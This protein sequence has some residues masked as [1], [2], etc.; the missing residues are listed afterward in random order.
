MP[1]K[2]IHGSAKSCPFVLLLKIEIRRAAEKSV[3]ARAATEHHP[4]IWWLGKS[5]ESSRMLLTA[6]A[7]GLDKKVGQVVQGFQDK[8]STDTG[9]LVVGGIILILF[10]GLYIFSAAGAAYLSIKLN[11]YLGTSTTMTVV[12]AILAFLFSDIYY[13][14]YAFFYNPLAK[15]RIRSNSGN[16]RNNNA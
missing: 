14:V 12:Y 13:P 1:E 6:Y 11:A 7:L 16:K 5:G 3:L 4:L 10:I 15:P 9:G 8:K 2:G